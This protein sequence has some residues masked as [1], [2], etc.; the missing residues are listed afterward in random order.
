VTLGGFQTE[1]IVDGHSYPI[2]VHVVSNN[3]L[4][5]KLLIG[6]SF[7]NMTNVN[8]KGVEEV[9]SPLSE[10]TYADAGCENSVP[11]VLK[12][13]IKFLNATSQFICSVTL[14]ILVK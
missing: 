4:R 7:L 12:N 10:A 5:Y 3:V 11:E 1:I 14:M 6:T 2:C 8:L 9:T 13:K